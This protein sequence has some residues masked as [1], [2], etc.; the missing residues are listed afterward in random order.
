METTKHF[1]KKVSE[2]AEVETELAIAE[3]I[4][5]LAMVGGDAVLADGIAVLLRGI[6]LVGE[7]VVLGIFLCQA[8]HVVVTIGLGEDAGG[9]DSE[10]AS[11]R[12]PPKR[13]GEYFLK[14]L[15][16]TMMASGRTFS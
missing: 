6:A 8:V 11:P 1:G 7:P 14:R 10:V 13:G 15:P 3:E 5:A 2:V 9:S 12:P 4:V 16:S